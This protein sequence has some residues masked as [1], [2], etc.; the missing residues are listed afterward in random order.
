[1]QSEAQMGVWT[2]TT[3]EVQG[4]LDQSSDGRIRI[5]LP[6]PHRPPDHG[7]IRV[8]VRYVTH[9]GKEL[10]AELPL[11]VERSGEVAR[12][13]SKERPAEE[14]PTPPPTVRDAREHALP[15]TSP[16][17]DESRPTDPSAAPMEA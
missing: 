14:L 1:R 15:L 5:E 2:F 12:T 9:R 7:R 8:Y 16:G 4:H 6:W 11:V 3:S 10:R 17:A 13:E